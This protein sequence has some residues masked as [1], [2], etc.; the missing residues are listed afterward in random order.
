MVRQ[1]GGWVLSGWVAVWLDSWVAGYVNGW[2]A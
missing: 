1:L 2:V